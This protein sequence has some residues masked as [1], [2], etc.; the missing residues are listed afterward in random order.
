MRM[1]SPCAACRF[2]TCKFPNLTT[3]KFLAPPSQILGTP[4][5]KDLQ[6]RPLLTVLEGQLCAS[7][8]RGG[9]FEKKVYDEQENEWVDNDVEDPVCEEQRIN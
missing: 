4:L 6:S 2:A 9:M 5:F 1:A 7:V 8:G 3:K